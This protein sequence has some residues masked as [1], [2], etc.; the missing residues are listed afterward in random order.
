[1]DWTRSKNGSEWS[2]EGQLRKYLRANRREVEEGED[3]DCDGWK[4]QRRICGRWRLRDGDIR[5]S[6]GN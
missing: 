1:M 3:V 5:Q 4:M 2:R 6:I